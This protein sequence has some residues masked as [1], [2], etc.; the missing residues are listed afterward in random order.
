M[1]DK[2]PQKRR[3]RTAPPKS[4]VPSSPID[5]RRANEKML[6]DVGKLLREKEFGSAEEANAYLQNL[7]ASGGI[8]A[9]SPQTPLERAQE[10]MYDA[11][12]ASGARRVK[13]ARR[14]LEISPD[15]ADAY[16]LLAEMAR[17][18]QEAKDLYEQGVRAGERALGPRAFEE[19]VGY[20][21]GII[22]TRPYM[23]A[24]EGLAHCLWLL[25]ER[26]Q[27]IEHLTAMLRLNPG[28]NQGVRYTLANWLLHEGA[29]EA[30]RKLLAQY[31][32]DAA[33]SW[34]YTRALW[35]FRREGASSKAG[36]ALK[37]AFRYN[38]FVPLYL[39]GRKKLPRRM[40]DYVGF[41][42][43]NEAVDYAVGAIEQWRRTPG[44][45]EWLKNSLAI[46]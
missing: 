23:R 10:L 5:F 31:K 38:S 15:C 32:D 44:A 35:L 21:W 20:F 13:L 7:L 24:R 19:D 34:T 2:K 41:G 1:S 16:V 22:E 18:P 43:E 14:S 17:S 37:E 6:Q 26:Q 8:P 3:G 45:L 12:E 30:L 11:W 36:K 25:D 29:D 4:S 27:A 39:L 46:S 33:A 9:S 40:P 28:D 42:D